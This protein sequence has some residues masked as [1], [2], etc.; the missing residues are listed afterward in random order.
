[1]YR[2]GRL[3]SFPGIPGPGLG[4]PTFTRAA[5]AATETSA[6]CAKPEI[7][8][9]LRQAGIPGPWAPRPEVILRKRIR[10]FEPHE[11]NHEEFTSVP[12]DTSKQEERG[13][14]QPRMLPPRGPMQFKGSTQHEIA[15]TLKGQMIQEWQRVLS[16]VGGTSN[17]HR[18][19]SQSKHP[20]E[21]LAQSL[22]KFEGSTLKTDM[23]Q[24]RT[25]L[26]FMTAQ[27]TPMS[28]MTSIIIADLLWEYGQGMTT[29]RQNPSTAAMLKALNFLANQAEIPLMQEALGT[30]LVTS[31]MS[32]THARPRKEAPPMM[33]HT[34]VDMEQQLLAEDTPEW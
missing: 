28:E 8:R 11:S 19:I 20:Q 2:P 10:T 21:M 5:K 14:K 4:R 3:T 32:T 31:F 16:I 24:V 12:R 13:M 29:K 1:M 6:G 17:L 15:D 33:F 25:L 30:K 9:E 22:L 27:N 18:H 26:D 34:V 7:G 23:G